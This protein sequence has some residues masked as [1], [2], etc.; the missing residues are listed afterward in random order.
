[1]LA[2]FLAFV[3]LFRVIRSCWHDPEFRALF[4]LMVVILAVATT[5]YVR[6]EGWSVLDALYFSVVTVATVG[7]GDIT[8]QTALGK[9]FTA[10]FLV[11]GVGIFVALAGKLAL[12]VI[13]PSLA[14]PI[15]SGRNIVS[16]NDARPS[17]PCSSDTC[18][19]KSG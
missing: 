6:V 17:Q 5:F 4:A 3:R 11:L 10:V 16:V 1:M 18:S 7:Y 8:P 19:E 14:T 2:F 12:V 9:L 13:Q 15:D